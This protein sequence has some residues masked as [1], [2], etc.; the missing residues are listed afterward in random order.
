MS[1]KP[2][3]ILAVDP[4]VEMGWAIFREGKLHSSGVICPDKDQDWQ[5]RMDDLHYNFSKLV[6]GREVDG[7]CCEWPA[8]FE[9]RGVVAAREGSLVKLACAVGVIMA[10]AFQNRLT[11]RRI[12]IAKWK[13]N[14]PKEAVKNRILKRLGQEA[15]KGLKTHAWDAVGIGLYVLGEF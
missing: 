10:V 7:V 13:G 8:F 1:L 11:F 9:E 4:G 6:E 3:R 14:M 15:C 2:L 12:E 5:N